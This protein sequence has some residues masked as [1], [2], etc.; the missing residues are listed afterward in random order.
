ML[1]SA[2]Q[3]GVHDALVRFG[4]KEAAGV[5][6]ALG[7]GRLQRW[8]GGLKSILVGQPG[9]AFVEGPNSFR[10]GGLLSNSNIWWPK[11]DG[12]RGMQKVM[13]WVQRASTIQ[14]AMQ[15]AHAAHGDQHEGALSNMLGTAGQIAGYA[16]GMPALGMLGAPLLSAA[17]R[18]VGHGV[19]HLL[20]SHPKDQ[21]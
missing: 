7:P 10:P 6:D 8:G 19:G 18:S 3:R 17:G 20:G 21:P 1:V 11:T 4:I 2:H 13:P 15:M 12:L 16:Y 5:L 9:R 14:G